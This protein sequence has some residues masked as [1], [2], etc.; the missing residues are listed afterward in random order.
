MKAKKIL[1][2]IHGLSARLDEGSSMFYEKR[3]IAATGE[4]CEFCGWG[5]AVCTLECYA[6]CCE[7]TYDA[8]RSLYACR[9]CA[10]QLVS[11]QTRESRIKAS[12][13]A[14]SGIFI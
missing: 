5:K 4:K 12:A 7:E 9:Q 1:E 11:G 3:K 8:H 13:E 2:A 14:A 6:E 10:R